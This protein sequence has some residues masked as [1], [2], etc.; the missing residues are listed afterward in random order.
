MKRF[1]L[2]TS[3]SL[4][5]VASTVSA[6]EVTLQNDSIAAGGSGN[7]QLGFINGEFGAA[8]F[9]PDF[10]MFP[11]QIK[12]VQI[13]WSA[14]IP[15]QA[16]NNVQ[17]GI[18]IYEGTPS[19]SNA[20]IFVSDPI[21]LTPQFLNEYD[22]ENEA[23]IIANPAPITVGMKFSDAPNG[24][25]LA[26][27]L[28]TDLD[29]CQPNKNFIFAVPGGWVP[30]CSFGVTGDFNIRIVVEHIELPCYPDCDNNGTLNV[31]DYICFGNAFATAQFY[32]DCDGNGSLNVFDYIC[33]GN[34]YSVGCP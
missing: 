17:D 19:A 7:V 8:T 1:A 11:L 30:S 20:A 13:G 12:R 9:Y 33:F 14:L 4:C 2:L 31:F 5:F 10:S 32:A 3:M 29:G 34:E 28:V 16:Q 6:Q 22:F 24:S 21:Q 26:A 15:G 27:S 25:F 23:I 18:F